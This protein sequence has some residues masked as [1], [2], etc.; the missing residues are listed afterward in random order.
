VRHLAVIL[1]P[2]SGSSETSESEIRKLFDDHDIQL[3][4][5]D[6][7]KGLDVLTK[8]IKA[9]KPQALIA[10]GGDGTV[11]ATANLAVRL[12]L[13]MGVIPSGTLNHFAKD[14]GL[15]MNP[16]E[17]ADLISRGKL[18]AID[19][20]SINDRVFVNNANLG[21]YPE[22]VLKRDKLSI[23][24]NK[25]LSAIVASIQ[26][27][28]RHQKQSFELSIDGQQHK[29]RA[30]SLFIGNNAYE[31]Q[32]LNFTSRQNLDQG[33]LQLVVIKTGRLRHL[34]SIG[35]NFILRN[36]HEKVDE[37]QAKELEIRSS[38]SDDNVA[39]DGEVIKL[40]M[41]LT[42]KIHAKALKVFGQ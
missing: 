39:I 2:K 30:G 28:R 21:G 14:M 13:P 19:Y 4:F 9:H 11:N 31:L 24:N 3:K 5:F 20:G 37:Y 33:N 25:W 35:I 42:I 16:Q 15:P 32:G 41:P 6:I 7:T 26:T 22:V 17:A 18:I 10:V 40:S 34:S 38:H 27:F 8:A 23:L 29:V 12:D 1:N 36:S